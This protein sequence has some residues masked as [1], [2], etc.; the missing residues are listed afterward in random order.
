MYK[1]QDT[2]EGARRFFNIDAES[3]AVAALLGLANEGKIDRSVA[4]QA[5]KDLKIDDPTAATQD[6]SAEDV[7]PENA[8]E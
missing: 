5:A 3:M 1:R 2:R 4:A 6:D 8:A 7:G